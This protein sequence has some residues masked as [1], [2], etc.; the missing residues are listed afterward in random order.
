MSRTNN[1]KVAERAFKALQKRKDEYIRDKFVVLMRTALEDLLEAHDQFGPLSHSTMEKHT[2]GFA[3]YH[4]GVEV[5][6]ETQNRGAIEGAIEFRLEHLGAAS[7]GW[8]GIVMSDMSFDWYNVDLEIGFL[9]YSAN[10]VRKN[11]HKIF[12]KI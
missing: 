9:N 4:N 1:D 7:K 8:V 2:L 6:L 3:I 12:K 5:A 10:E 11:F